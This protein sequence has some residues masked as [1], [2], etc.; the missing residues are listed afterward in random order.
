MPQLFDLCL[1]S[2]RMLMRSGPWAVLG[3]WQLPAG[4]MCS[5]QRTPAHLQ[6]LA[7]CHGL[8]QLLVPAG[9]TA[10]RLCHYAL[11]LLSKKLQVQGLTHGIYV[12]QLCH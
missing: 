4:G 1:N 9:D 3:L 6:P 11:R 12:W 5:E 2:G 7:V 10:V 8:L